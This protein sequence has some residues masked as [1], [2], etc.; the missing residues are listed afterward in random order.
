VVD[1]DVV[2]TTW[3]LPKGRKFSVVVHKNIIR[4]FFILKFK[5]ST[6][7]HFSFDTILLSSRIMNEMRLL[8]IYIR[9]QT[10][11]QKSNSNISNNFPLV[12]I[13]AMKSKASINHND[14]LSIS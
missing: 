13:I 9:I 10:K 2:S 5:F 14:S 12:T 1:S 7:F 3:D 4:G 8:C 6:G 11:D